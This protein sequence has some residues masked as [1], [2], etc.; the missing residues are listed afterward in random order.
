MRGKNYKKKYFQYALILPIFICF[1]FMLF[2]S[3]MGCRDDLFEAASTANDERN[4]LHNNDGSGG[5]TGTGDTGGGGTITPP[6]YSI[7]ALAD[8][9]GFTNVLLS[10]GSTILQSI[11]VHSGATGGKVY[12]DP[13][14]W[15]FVTKDYTV[16]AI[17][18]EKKVEYV[19]ADIS[20]GFAEYN[21]STVTM[22]KKSIYRFDETKNPPWEIIFDYSASSQN[23]VSIFRA[24]DGSGSYMVD[25]SASFYHINDIDNKVQDIPGAPTG[26]F[27]FDSYEGIFFAGSIAQISNSN[28]KSVAANGS[29]HSFAILNSTDIFAGGIYSTHLD[30]MRIDFSQT[31]ALVYYNFGSM[32]GNMLISAY[33]SSRLAIGVNSSTQGKN[34]LYLFDTAN[35]SIQ[36][37][38]STFPVYSVS[39]L[40]K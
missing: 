15:V 4:D 9:G 37:Q 23:F 14:G 22:V 10:D 29:F 8:T 16:Y 1:S 36:H 26:A 12:L 24:S 35:I 33:D 2:I 18:D 21:G 17:R 20:L 7:A 19:F 28:D 3:G 25:D 31:Y 38:L 5:D 30:L 27:F 13:R 40:R 6:A 11:Q 39:T 32:D 34:G